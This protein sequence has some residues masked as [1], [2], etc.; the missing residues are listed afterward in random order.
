MKMFTFNCF[1]VRPLYK[2]SLIRPLYKTS[3][4]YFSNPNPSRTFSTLS[5]EVYKRSSITEATQMNTRLSKNSFNQVS[6]S[7]TRRNTR[8]N[9]FIIKSYENLIIKSG[10][11]LY[12]AYPAACKPSQLYPSVRDGN[13]IYHLL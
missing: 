4:P 10:T 11:P 5:S 3:L 1:P 2:T 9:R 7:H 12:K 8:M 6:N 13:K